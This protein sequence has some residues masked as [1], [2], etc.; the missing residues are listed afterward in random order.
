MNRPWIYPIGT[1]VVAQKDVMAANDRIAHPAGAVGVIVAAP[2]DR[3]H[4]YRVRFNDGF[5]APIHH[6]QLVQLD[7]YKTGVIEGGRADDA[8]ADLYRRVIYRCVSGPMGWKTT[9]RTPIGAGFSCPP[10]KGIGR[11]SAC[12]NKSR[13]TR[14]RRFIGSFK[15]SSCWR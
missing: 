9:V 5:E 4:A 2:M 7:E 1:Q 3:S 12:R 10:R 11:C 13:M 15:N 14:R 8:G 6:D